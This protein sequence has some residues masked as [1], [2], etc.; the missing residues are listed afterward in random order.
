MIARIWRGITSL[1]V[2][3]AYREHLQEMAVPRLKG[4]AGLLHSYILQREQ[5]DKC[6]FQ[7]VT[8][9][10]DMDAMQTWAGGD[11]EQAVYLDEEDRYLLDM[12]P[13]VRLYQAHEI[14][15]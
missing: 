5:G 8:F 6:E 12:E 9:W 1:D 14:L 15:D 10:R 2:A 11:P 3:D 4:T 13:L 7:V